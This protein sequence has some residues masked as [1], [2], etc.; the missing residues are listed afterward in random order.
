M[1]GNPYDPQP[2]DQQPD[3]PR[4]DL[5]KGGPAT[6]P[7]S[8]YGTPY[9]QQSPYG[10]QGQQSQQPYG[11]PSYGQQPY[12]QPAYGQQQPY[13]A[14]PYGNLPQKDGSATTAM[15]LGIVAVGGMFICG[16]TILLSPVALV[17][18]LNSKKRI[19]A[20][21][22][23]LMGRSEAQTGFVLG[24]IGCVLL[25]LAIVAIILIIIVAVASDG[26]SSSYDYD[27]TYDYNALAALA[28]PR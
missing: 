26:G 4:V 3:E 18:G 17:M 9:G 15:V 11:Q 8:P 21:G 28:L 13:G 19:D 27:N 5:G 16:V 23:R 2:D 10:Q 25:A 22:G 1:T 6:P 7:P 20:S 14:T 24:I 12:G